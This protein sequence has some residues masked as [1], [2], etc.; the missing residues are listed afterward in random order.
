MGDWKSLGKELMAIIWIWVGG[1]SGG[2]D[3]S[4]NGKGRSRGAAHNHYDGVHSH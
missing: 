3:K 1:W 2:K 4:L